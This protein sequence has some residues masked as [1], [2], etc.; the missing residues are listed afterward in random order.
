MTKASSSL[1]DLRLGIWVAPGQL[2][3]ASS[4]IT[5]SAASFDLTDASHMS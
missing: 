1:Q 4:Y 3:A 2:L 5:F